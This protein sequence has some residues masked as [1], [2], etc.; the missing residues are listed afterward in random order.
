MP[1][2][3]VL[4]PSLVSVKLYDNAG[5]AVTVNVGAEHALD[6]NEAADVHILTDGEDHILSLPSTVKSVSRCLEQRLRDL[7]AYRGE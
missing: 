1:R 2:I 7:R 4:L 5:G 3:R 6:D